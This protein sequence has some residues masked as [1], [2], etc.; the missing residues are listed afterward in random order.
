MMVGWGRGR[1]GA[2]PFILVFLLGPRGHPGNPGGS[3]SAT[4]EP[5]PPLLPRPA[6]R[7]DLKPACF[8]LSKTL[9]P[10]A[11]GGKPPWPCGGGAAGEGKTCWSA[12]SSRG[13]RTLGGPTAQVT[14]GG[15]GV[16]RA[17]APKKGGRP[18]GRTC[19]RVTTITRVGG[20]GPPIGPPWTMGLGGRRGTTATAWGPM[21]ADQKAALTDGGGG[22]GGAFAF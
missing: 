15:R 10:M 21:A 4:G 2:S 7:G 22:R 5:P 9:M 17:G 16:S 1:G 14:L 20:G 18:W 13:A 19:R 3:G 12:A 8:S 6:A 11:R